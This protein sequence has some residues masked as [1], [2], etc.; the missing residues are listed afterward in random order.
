MSSTPSPIPNDKG[1]ALLS[2]LLLDSIAASFSKPGTAQGASFRKFR[3]TFNRVFKGRSE[4]PEAKELEQLHKNLAQTDLDRL[5]QR[6]RVQLDR[7]I[8]PNKQTKAAW[9]ELTKAVPNL[10]ILTNL[11]ELLRR[12]P[13]NE[14]SGWRLFFSTRPLGVAELNLLDPL[15]QKSLTPL[16]L[17]LR[18]LRG[19]RAQHNNTSR[20]SEGNPVR[21]EWAS[22]P[23]KPLVAITSFRT[24]IKSWEDRIKGT[25][26]LSLSRF[27]RLAKI[28]R[29]VCQLD[30]RPHYVVFPE[31]SIPR[32]W[33]LEVA[34][35]LQ[36]SGISL[37]AGVE[38]EVSSEERLCCHN[39]VFM[40]LQ[41][42]D[43]GYRTYRLLRQDKIFPALEEEEELHALSN[44]M[45]CP[46]EPF[47]YGYLSNPDS[48]RPVFQH[49]KLHFGV[50]ICNELTDIVARSSY[51]GKV[52]ALFV[53]EWNKDIKTFSSLVESAASD[54]H[55]FVI[56]VNNREYGDSRI[57]VPA[58]NDW[59]R[60]IVRLQGGVNDYVVVGE[61]DVPALRHFQSRHRSPTSK[62][63]KFKPV[64][65]GFRMSSLRNNNQLLN[66]PEESD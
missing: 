64:P 25:P 6:A 13:R 47:D 3:E 27:K 63:A 59:D 49:G 14:Q 24:D 39:S 23:D 66:D 55:C 40:I 18:C 58:K 37:V 9:K 28:V 32:E 44:L 65:T 15:T 43:L 35:A 20:T 54:V 41:S 22:A 36:R 38:Y 19:N 48:P 7:P 10:E 56:Q 45:L 34:S 31:L 61:L 30:R 57:R 16:C 62:D 29:T 17:W 52:D 46:K 50:M 2:L 42:T 60:D 12:I 33:I 11:D 5:G 53:A 51:R 4:L 26:D 21:V 8:K 1:R